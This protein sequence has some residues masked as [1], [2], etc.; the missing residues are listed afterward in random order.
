MAE[1]LHLLPA[2]PLV[3]ALL[4]VVASVLVSVLI[5]LTLHRALARL[6]SKTATDLD[7]QIVGALRSPLFL[8]AVFAGLYFA[9]IQLGDRVPKGIK[10]VTASV[11][12][13]V[14][15]FVW[16][17]ALMRIGTITFRALSARAHTGSMIQPTSLPLFDIGFKVVVTVAAIYFVFLAWHM[18]LTAWAAS[19][20]II[21]VAVGF[22]AKDSLSN[23]FAGIF[24]LADAPYKVGDFI[25]L[26][27]GQ[28]GRVTA[29]GMRSTRI[30]TLDHVEI[31]VPNG[32]IA[33][34]RITNEAGGPN[35]TQRL[36]VK[37]SAAYG[38]DVDQVRDV[39]LGCAEGVDHLCADPP[40]EVRFTS[41]GD[42][43]LDFELLCWVSEPALREPVLSAL[44]T[45]V[46]KAFAK[47]GIEIPYPKRDVYVK[48]LPGK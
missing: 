22:A 1:L 44:N 16:S 14:A 26:E 32:I 39:L 29:I 30:L 12:V 5:E 38:S 6:A 34:S 33:G 27:G 19:A 23:L 21:G 43:G 3:R 4:I 15:I 8:S 47:A 7:D 48:E 41:F 37:V 17:R 28:R 36:A 9:T 18:D 45:R 31:T 2:N 46:Y 42:S 40:P 25:V 10:A 24:I 11:V 20:G 35:T 13:T